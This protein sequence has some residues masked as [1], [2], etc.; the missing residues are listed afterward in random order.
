VT[1]RRGVF[2][3]LLLIA[4]GIVFLLANF[5]FIAG[6][7]W[8]AIFSLWPLLLIL[9]GLD[10]AFGRRWPLAALAAE[11]L[12]IAAGLALVASSPG[13]G[14]GIFTFGNSGGG[15][16]PDVTLVR[17]NATSLAVTLN[18]GAGRYHVSGGAMELVTAHSANPDLRLRASERSGRA[19]V[20]IDQTGTPG[21]FRGTSSADIEVRIASDVPTSFNMN[22][23]AGEFDIDLSDVRVTDARI[24]TGASTTRLVLPKPAG[25]VPVRIGAG[26]STV[27]IT[28]PEGIEAQVSTSGG[29]LSLR[30][31][32]SRLGE[33]GGTGGCVACGS[34]VQTS[35][36][37]TAKDRVSISISAG[38]SS[39][40]VR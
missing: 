2:W 38:A 27:V 30:S 11:V 28:V 9:I 21:I 33:G 16:A 32:N 36:Y 22:A 14:S 18:G 6:V 10:V 24:N 23:G 17:T 7:S 13:A 34:A 37:A 25:D 26:A 39:I 1:P 12:V 35:G 3:P 29:L 40:V 8:L 31:D 4:L 19:D 15:G 5:G 20:R